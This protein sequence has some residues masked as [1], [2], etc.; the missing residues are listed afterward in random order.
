MLRIKSNKQTKLTEFYIKKILE[1]KTLADFLNK[2][3]YESSFKNIQEFF[4]QKFLKFNIYKIK[5][6][7]TIQILQELSWEF[8][9]EFCS[10]R[11]QQTTFSESV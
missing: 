7:L 8:K 1:V 9:K 5:E 2:R 10:R 4:I 3:F 11:L 6:C